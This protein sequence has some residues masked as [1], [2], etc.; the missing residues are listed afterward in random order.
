MTKLT[1][2]L[3]VFAFL[4]LQV[5][6]SFACG[7]DVSI[8]E[9]NSITMCENAATDLNASPGYV[10]YSWYG[11]S[12]GTG[13]TITPTAGG[14]YYVDATDGVACVSTDSIFV[15]FNPAP[16]P[17][18]QS[19]EGT[20]ICPSVGGTNLSLTSTYSSYLWSTGDNG[21]TI[22]VTTSGNYSIVVEDANGCIG[23]SDLQVDFLDFSITATENQPVCYDVYVGLQATGGGTYLWSTGETSDYIVVSPFETTNYTV[24]I[25][26]GTCQATANH[27]VTVYELPQYDW[28]DTLYYGVNDYKAIEGPS[29]YSNFQWSPIN[30]VSDTIGQNIA[31]SGV[32]SGTVF[33][34]MQSEDGCVTTDEVYIQIVDLT[35]P[36]GFSPNRDFTNDFFVIPELT[37]LSG[38]ITIW[39]R[40]GEMV[41]TADEY[42][43]DWEGKCKTAL[44]VGNEDL[45]EGTYFYAID[46]QGVKFDGYLTLKR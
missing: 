42:K 28:A 34:T 33:L 23:T 29:N 44:C 7:I 10:S 3:S 9:G 31:Y 25:T 20:N 27:T 6:V 40:W 32:E 30:N 35:I 12:T 39:N 26:N 38:K 37:N 5:G 4:I 8:V 36:E 16:I 21:S 13:Q 24:T 46:V 2:L 1:R 11:P 15:V 19:S 22:N 45:P 43:N 17:V 14:W 18:I 41:F